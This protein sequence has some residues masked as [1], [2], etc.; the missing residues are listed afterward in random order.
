ML[1]VKKCAANRRK[2][3]IVIAFDMRVEN[4]R[5]SQQGCPV[6]CENLCFLIGAARY[7]RQI[8]QQFAHLL[9]LII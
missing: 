4:C 3:S 1:A 7:R 5:Q 9:P 8:G 2:Y 6:V